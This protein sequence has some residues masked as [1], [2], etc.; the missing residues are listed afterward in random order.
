VSAA[1]LDVPA[2]VARCLF[3]L[4]LVHHRLGDARGTEIWLSR[5]EAVLAHA[6][7]LADTLA[8]ASP[9]AMASAGER[10]VSLSGKR[11]AT[12]SAA[13]AVPAVAVQTLRLIVND[14]RETG[15]KMTIIVRYAWQT[16]I[17]I[18]HSISQLHKPNS[19]HIGGSHNMRRSVALQSMNHSF[20]F[21][22]FRVV[23]VLTGCIS[24]SVDLVGLFVSVVVDVV[25]VVV[26]V[27]LSS[28]ALF[29]ALRDDDVDGVESGRPLLARSCRSSA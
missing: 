22:R 16:F 20:A 12:L 10:R 17:S 18:R 9:T 23:L 7:S 28:R 5:A 15:V 6:A 11:V 3:P 27:A 1:P 4:A 13:N 29:D 26:V 24:T 2:N 14:G 21:R 8:L 25:D 19:Q